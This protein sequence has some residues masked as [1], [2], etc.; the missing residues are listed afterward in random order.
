M[1]TDTL[2]MLQ[3][4]IPEACQVVYECHVAVY[5]GVQKENQDQ[6]IRYD[7]AVT[8]HH[9]SSTDTPYAICSF[10]CSISV[11]ELF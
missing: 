10:T 11:E 1:G 7:G 4:G 8:W 9:W 5:N 3:R 2:G 6:L